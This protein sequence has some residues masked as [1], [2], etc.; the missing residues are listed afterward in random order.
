M[1][2]KKYI[3]TIRQVEHLRV[4]LTMAGLGIT[5]AGVDLTLR[6][7]EAIGRLGG[8]FDLQSA[9]NLQCAVTKRWEKTEDREETT[10]GW[11]KKGYSRQ[12]P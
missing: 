12:R 6:V 9:V 10:I 7:H 2:K 11:K 3:P 1:R 5:N 4:A 8:D